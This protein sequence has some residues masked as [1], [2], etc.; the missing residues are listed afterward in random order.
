MPIINK[1]QAE[2]IIRT[3]EVPLPKKFL[4]ILEKYGDNP[5]ALR[6][7]GLAYAIDQ[8]VDLVTQDVGGVHLYTMNKADVA[9]SIYQA[10][11]SLFE[12]SMTEVK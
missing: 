11:H 2:R 12:T 8:I 10:T 7:A 5:V 3:A 1:K 9:R 4:A 6:D